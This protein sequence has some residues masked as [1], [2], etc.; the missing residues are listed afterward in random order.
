[1]GSASSTLALPIHIQHRLSTSSIRSQTVPCGT[2][3]VGVVLPFQ[4]FR[5]IARLLR[6]R[7]GE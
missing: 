4:S 1:M 7:L 6:E 5:E 3:P 2:G